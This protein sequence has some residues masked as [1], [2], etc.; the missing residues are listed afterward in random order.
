MYEGD[1]PS[2]GE[3][4][5]RQAG[6][7]APSGAASQRPAAAAPRSDRVLGVRD[8]R[9]RD[10]RRRHQRPRRLRRHRVRRW[11][12]RLGPLPGHAVRRPSAQPGRL[13]RRRQDAPL[14]PQGELLR[15]AAGEGLRQPDRRTRCG[16]SSGAT[17]STPTAWWA[18]GPERG[19]PARCRRAS[20]PGTGPASSA[21]APPA[22][23]RL[24][25]TTIG[26]A[27]RDL[28]CGTKVTLKYRGRFVQGQGD[29]PRPVRER[30]P[31]GP[32]P[33]KRL[34]SFTST[35]TGHDPRRP[36]QV[37]TTR[38]LGGGGQ[39]RRVGLVLR[40]RR[41]AGDQ[42]LELVQRQVADRLEDLLVG[43]AD[44]ARLLVQ[45]ERA[46]PVGLERRLQ[47]GE[48]R[49]LLLVAGGEAAGAG[50]LVEAEAGA[51]APTSRAGRC[52]SCPR[53]ARRPPG[54]SARA[55]PAGGRRRAARS[56]SAC[57]RAGRRARR[58]AR[59]RTW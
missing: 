25:R 12:G 6:A 28:P 22:A 33:A 11:H 7:S 20:P 42:A 45:V 16:A 39:D 58:R 34:E 52:C 8:G 44:L 27:H 9:D 21:T 18:A 54:R 17:A 26:V 4:R 24:R 35:A 36:D 32:D 14:A 38:R 50:D 10:G 43:P 55:S 13:R 53:G 49:R 23:R 1:R 19:S 37:A 29:R 15:S 57:R 30:R 31:L 47:E 59:R 41:G 48:Q 51:R 5:I 2:T 40:Q 46:G 3:N 56:A